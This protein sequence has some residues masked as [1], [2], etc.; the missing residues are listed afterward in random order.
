MDCPMTLFRAWPR[1]FLGRNGEFVIGVTNLFGKI[2]WIV[3][4]AIL[5][6]TGFAANHLSHHSC[7][8]TLS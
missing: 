5:Q 6:H 4:V 1:F 8:L 2:L 7:E 3:H